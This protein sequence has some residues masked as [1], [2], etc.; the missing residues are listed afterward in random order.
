MCIYSPHLDKDIKY[1]TCNIHSFACIFVIVYQ[2]KQVYSSV[3]MCN[4]YNA[5]SHQE[6]CGAIPKIANC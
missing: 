1:V 5:A 4:M 2:K 3:S 6:K